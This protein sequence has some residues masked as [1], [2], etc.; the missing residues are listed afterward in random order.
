MNLGT[1]KRLVGR[2]I[3]QL[4]VVL[5]FAAIVGIALWLMS[6]DERWLALPLASIA[7]GVLLVGTQVQFSV[8]AV[9]TLKNNSQK[10][11]VALRAATQQ[12]DTKTV[13]IE[14]HLKSLVQELGKTANEKELKS[15]RT[16]LVALASQSRVLTDQQRFRFAE[17]IELCQDHVDRQH[18]IELRIRRLMSDGEAIERRTAPA[19][20]ETA[21]A[22]V[23][24]VGATTDSAGTSVALDSYVESLWPSVQNHLWMR[25]LYSRS[26][27]IAPKDFLA[28]PDSMR[29]GTFLAESEFLLVDWG[30]DSLTF[31]LAQE[32][33]LRGLSTVAVESDDRLA[34]IAAQ[35]LDGG[36]KTL[37]IGA[38][39]T[40]EI[41][42]ELDAL[43]REPASLLVNRRL[44][45][46]ELAK[47]EVVLK[48]LRQVGR[49]HLAED[50]ATEG[51]STV[52]ALTRAGFSRSQAP[53]QYM[54]KEA[55]LEL[56]ERIS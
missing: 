9:H 28:S 1:I 2:R 46:N 40:H 44:N 3:T 25:D 17:I 51:D 37:S 33:A 13:L 56:W 34:D 15:L 23:A 49:V 48:D 5:L 18:A 22:Q 16:E 11:S 52:G 29:A 20:S 36:L 26:G 27:S 31:H 41:G 38:L 55:G 45:D 42:R 24:G 14:R 35:A 12:L 7:A 50:Q 30:I 4:H 53:E 6:S 39:A 10:R 32:R 43:V 21:T 54:T 8:D 47:L 19:R